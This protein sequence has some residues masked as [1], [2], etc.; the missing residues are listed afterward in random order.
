MKSYDVPTAL[1]VFLYVGFTYRGV[2]M[3]LN[4]LVETGYG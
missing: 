3:G 2:P 1:M 4:S